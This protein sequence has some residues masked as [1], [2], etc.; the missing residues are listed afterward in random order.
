YL[1]AKTARFQDYLASYQRQRVSLLNKADPKTGDYPASV[2]NTWALN[3]Q[4]VEKYPVSAN[5]LRV[6]AFLSP[7][8]IPLELLSEGASQ[9]G[10]VLAEVLATSEDPLVL[11][12]SMEPITRYSLIRLDV[13]T[14]TYSI[15]RLVAQSR[16][17]TKLIR[18]HL[19][20]PRWDEPILLALGFVGLDAPKDASELLE[21]AILAQGEEA[22]KMSLCPSAFEEILGWDFLFALRC[23][24]DQLPANSRVVRQ[25]VERLA[26]E[27]LHPT[28][29]AKFRRYQ[30]A[31]WDRLDYIKASKTASVLS[32]L[33]ITG[34]SN[35]DSKERILAVE[36]LGR[37]GYASN[38][39]VNALL[40]SLKDVDP[41]VRIQ[42]AE[43][44]GQL[45]FSSIELETALLKAQRD[46]EPMVQMRAAES[47]ERLGHRSEK[48][49][50]TLLKALRIRA[51]K[52]L[53]EESGESEAVLLSALNHFDPRVRMQAAESL[54]QLGKSTNKAM[55]AL[56]GTLRD[57]D[58]GVRMQAAES[59]ILLGYSVSEIT[60]LLKALC[61]NDDVHLNLN[62]KLNP[63]MTSE[64]NKMRQILGKEEDELLRKLKY[65]DPRMRIHAAESLGQLG[66][67]SDE[68]VAALLNSTNDHNPTVRMRVIESLGLLG[69]ESE[70]VKASLNKALYASDHRVRV[71]AV[72]SLRL[73]GQMTNKVR[74][75]LL[76]VIQ[77][78]D[79]W[80]A[81]SEAAILLGQIAPGDKPTVQ[82][83]WRGLLDS[84][85]K[86][87]T[88]CAQALAQ[89]GYRFPSI[90]LEIAEKLKFSIE[91]PEFDKP[92]IVVERS[93]HEYAFEGLWLIA[94]SGV[95]R[96]VSIDLSQEA[97]LCSTNCH[98]ITKLW[99]I[100]NLCDENS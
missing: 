54:G 98:L 94:A 53:G 35:A 58:R 84:N 75:T 42:V 9:L 92:D 73:L 4:E 86:V 51:V 21:T 10:Q 48:V 47:L 3:F 20:D 82:A 70:K 16:T 45:G 5:I 46:R 12:E 32:P 25:L 14:Q 30:Q 71:K 60:D 33:L 88:S 50:T 100:C 28:A 41:R 59:L 8:A 1:A 91:N 78:L 19:H 2:A 79:Y 55:A 52:S 69:D 87:R 97:P 56:L 72:E 76:E 68:V 77:N 96:E 15:H 24:G 27:L 66:Q 67:A 83:L 74:A 65:N 99:L 62:L 90:A 18:K 26:N 37:L 23:L 95:F 31:L 80:S 39:V 61:D 7:V 11:Y 57:E 29:S 89:L 43:G 85:D 13:D 36:S 40:K 64:L 63:Q 17:R 81:R 49:V 34:L 22:Q 44:L 38:E 6:S 93:A